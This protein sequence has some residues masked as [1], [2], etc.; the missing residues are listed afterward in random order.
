[1][2]TPS[3]VSTG[4]NQVDLLPS[5]RMVTSITD[6]SIAFIP[7]R[8]SANPRVRPEEFALRSLSGGRIRIDGFLAIGS[9]GNLHPLV[10]RRK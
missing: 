8:A 5:A 1:M 2:G 4:S 3:M 9:E 7:G 10:D 6:G